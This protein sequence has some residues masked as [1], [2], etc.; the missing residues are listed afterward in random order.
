MWG[1]RLPSTPAGASARPDQSYCLSCISSPR[2]DSVPAPP[3]PTRSVHLG[4]SSPHFLSPLFPHGRSLMS[5]G[6]STDWGEGF[7]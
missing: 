4:F 5:T 7:C 3:S 1:P 2:E 6:P